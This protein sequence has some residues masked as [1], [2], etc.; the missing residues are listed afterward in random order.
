VPIL[1]DL[2]DAPGNRLTDRIGL[3]V[4]TKVVSRDLVDEVVASTG[5]KERRS[6]LLS[7]RVMVYY[8][9]AMTLFYEDAYEEVMQ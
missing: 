4:L 2:A 6:R 5:S 8:V 1:Q 3:G 9:L 7:A